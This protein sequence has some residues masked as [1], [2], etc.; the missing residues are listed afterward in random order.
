MEHH[1]ARFFLIPHSTDLKSVL[2]VQEDNLWVFKPSHHHPTTL[3]HH[4]VDNDIHDYPLPKERVL[5]PSSLG[6][7]GQL[8]VTQAK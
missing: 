3:S 8:D 2:Q 5:S 6:Q 7:W 4:L 1:L